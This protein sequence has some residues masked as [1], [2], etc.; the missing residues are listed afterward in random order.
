MAEGEGDLG[1][2]EEEALLSQQ[3]PT[4]ELCAIYQLGDWR[5]GEPNSPSPC[6]EVRA[7]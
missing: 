5:C 2:E 3:S 4:G 7:K 1:E 6:P